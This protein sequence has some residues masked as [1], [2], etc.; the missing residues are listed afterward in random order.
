L[1]VS[2]I[3]PGVKKVSF[4]GMEEKKTASGNRAIDFFLPHDSSKYNA[5]IELVPV[6][7]QGT[8]YF[9]DTTDYDPVTVPLKDGKVSINPSII[10][11]KDQAFAYRFKL[12][13]KD[14]NEAPKYHTDGG[15]RTENSDE[16]NYTVV[17]R[18]RAPITNP[19][20][21]I[22]HLMVDSY[23]VGYNFNKNGKISADTEALKKAQN[24]RRTPFNQYGGNTA[25]VVTDL[26][27][28][29]DLGYDFILATPNGLIGNDKRSSHGYWTNNP[30]QGPENG[31]NKLALES[32]KKGMSIILD[33]AF[34]NEGM[35]GDRIKHIQKW[36]KESPF[37]NNF[38]I[39]GKL[40]IKNL[41]NV[42]PKSEE[43]KE[44]YSH[45]KLNIVNGSKKYAFNKDEIETDKQTRDPKKLTIVQIYD[46]RLIT[47]EQKEQIKKGQVLESYGK[48]NT[49]N[50]YEITND[51]QSALLR[52]FEVSEDEL[53]DFE[54]RIK[55]NKDLYKT[56]RLGFMQTVLDFQNFNIDNQANGFETWDGNADIAKLRYTYTMA[57]EQKASLAGL[58]KEEKKAL[59]QGAYQNQDYIQKVGMYW[60]K[61]VKNTLVEYTAKTLNKA[62]EQKDYREIFKNSKDILPTHS[63]DT[64]SDDVIKNVLANTYVIPELKTTSNA[65]ERIA[66]DIMNLPLESIGFSSDLSAVLGSPYLAKRAF[67]KEDVSKTRY[68]LYQQKNYKNIPDKYRDVYRDAEDLFIDKDNS[69]TEFAYEAITQADTEGK[70]IDKKT[71]KLTDSGKLMLP[72]VANDIM[73]FAIVKSAAPD[74]KVETNENGELIYDEKALRAINLKNLG[75]EGISASSPEEEATKTLHTIRKGLAK[76]SEDDKKVLVDN[77][78]Q[79]FN[80]VKEADLKMAYVTVDRTASGL[81]W[82]TDATK[83]NAPIGE[84][85]DKQANLGPAMDESIE[86][87][88]GFTKGIKKVN[89]NAYIIA[90]MTDTDDL[91]KLSG[92]KSGKYSN[93]MILE[94]AFVSDTGVSGLSN[95]N[96]FF[97][98]LLGVVSRAADTGAKGKADEL[99]LDIGGALKKDMNGENDWGGKNRGFLYE[100]PNDAAKISHNFTTNHDKPRLLSVLALDMGLFHGETTDQAYADYLLGQGAKY[101]TK[102]LA[103]AKAIDTAMGLSIDDMK[104]SEEDKEKAKGQLKLGLQ[105]LVNGEFQGKKFNPES[106]GVAPLDMAINDVIVQSKDLPKQLDTDELKNRTFEKMLKPATEKLLIMDK[107]LAILPGRNTSYAGDEYGATGYESPCKNLYGQNRNVAH[108]EWVE[109][110]QGSKDRKEFLATFYDEK[111][112]ISQLRKQPGLSAL[113]KGETTIL[114]ANGDKDVLAMFRYDKMS[115]LICLAH[116]KNIN[117]DTFQVD[118]NLENPN[119]NT[120]Q[121]NLT[122][123]H[124]NQTAIG[125]IVGG[126]AA[127]T[128]FVNAKDNK[129]LLGVFG[130]G[131]DKVLRQI[132]F[133]TTEDLDKYTKAME[134]GDKAALDVLKTLSLTAENI[135]L[136]DNILVFRKLNFRGK[137]QQNENFVKIQAYLNSK[138]YLNTNTKQRSAI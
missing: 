74:F 102:A 75:G 138:Q 43:G 123:S 23:N 63:E 68:E 24:A 70:L 30:Y 129:T 80:S 88:Q 33:G 117:K 53:P 89:P 9:A 82:R 31:V 57:D 58:S 100:Y 125:G 26:Q 4:K 34:V 7:K 116:T 131:K 35:E 103:M 107:F 90:E 13:D 50:H 71:Q 111:Q 20:G 120:S 54:K 59:Q 6:K 110:E 78:K 126:L 133:K 124:K 79:R 42:D 77:L 2:G 118:T 81:N 55:D 15:I 104:L 83:D 134:T 62:K 19:G 11:F 18:D 17:F 99:K 52:E 37:F 98:S 135:K 12:E 128:Y 119:Y 87:W 105:N 96:Y 28:L 64:M 69:L 76:I 48:H 108:R 46:D 22:M 106:F 29:K 85:R 97:S 91:I 49:D 73:K 67:E 14:G 56:N 47:D 27:R 92:G 72:L 66:E 21:S 16:A 39:D 115:E 112:K 3:N 36:G 94:S 44:I 60:T 93:N 1:L 86:F 25:G 51:N 5:S 38:K 84:V 109:A 45:I 40:T 10:A 121:I 65:K 114:D 127:G 132:G 130:E 122:P 61:S 101:N 95:Y 137:Q 8:S 113:S 32:Y 136:N 41:P